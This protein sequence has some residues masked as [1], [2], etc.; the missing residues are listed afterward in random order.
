MSTLP[1]GASRSFPALAH[2]YADLPE[3]FHARVAPT[4]VRAPR[5]L[6]LNT[7]LC[8]TLDIEPDALPPQAWAGL[9]SGNDLPRGARPVAMAYAGHQ[10]G[11]FVPQLGDGRAILL[12]ELRGADGTLRD[13]HLKGA[14]RTPFSRSG[15]GRAA[16]G[17]V[18]REYLVSE[19]MHALGI[20]TTRALAAVATGETVQRE[21]PRPG[22]ILARV[23]ASHLRVGTFEYFAARGDVPSLK[24]LADFTRA[25]H[26]TQHGDQDPYLALL[27]SVLEGQAR[28]VAQ[29]MGIGFVHGVMNTDNSALSGETLDYG[30]CAF[31]D[32]YHPGAVFSAIDHHGRY[33]YGNQPRIADWNLA[34]LAEC[35]LPL[36]DTDP[37]RAVDRVMPILERFPERIGA[38]WLE[39]MRRKLGLETA[40]T[41]D[42]GLIQELLTLMEREEADFT[43]TFHHLVGLAGD[44][45]ARTPPPGLRRPEAFNEWLTRWRERLG[46]EPAS[47]ADRSRAM[48]RV[49]PVRIPRNHRV[50]Q[51]LEAAHSG[52]MAP[53]LALLEAVTHP[54]EA[55]PEWAAFDTPP[56]PG[57]RVTRTF[58][59]T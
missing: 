25:R 55:R 52:E 38:H 29:W 5:L 28:L 26:P 31:L 27:A 58:C 54:F 46:H 30:P 11:Q 15:D 39:G 37:R 6:V 36:V 40:E 34:R 43:R 51:A 44:P 33:A 4:P 7:A 16:L 48:A 32:V 12:G 35:L 49:N 23:A 1:P 3:A 14:G 47:P 57:E 53:F 45:E 59:G 42:T 21:A 19:A 10:F 22:A 20:P 18:L 24:R 2:D 50:E 56:G 17:P 41:E 13:L 8:R 9:L